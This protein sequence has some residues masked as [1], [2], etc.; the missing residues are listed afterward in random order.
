MGDFQLPYFITGEQ[1]HVYQISLDDSFLGR[2]SEPL[3][4]FWHLA[5]WLPGGL[6]E[7]ACWRE[8]ENC[9]ANQIVTKVKKCPQ[10]LAKLAF[11]SNN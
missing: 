7:M 2:L 11:N 4:R 5:Q 1:V 8:M 10:K 3:L 6:L 9:R